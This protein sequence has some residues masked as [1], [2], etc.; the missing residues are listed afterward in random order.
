MNRKEQIR[1]VINEVV[2]KN[3][4]YSGNASPQHNIELAMSDVSILRHA[5]PEIMEEAGWV[6]KHKDNNKKFN[7]SDFENLGG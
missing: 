1:K 4:K 2:C 5:D 3:V 7:D 6:K